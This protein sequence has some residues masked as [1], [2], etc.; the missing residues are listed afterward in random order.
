MKPRKCSQMSFQYRK[1]TS[2]SN[3][4]VYTRRGDALADSRWH[5]QTPF[6]FHITAELLLEKLEGAG[7]IAACEYLKGEARSPS[8]FQLI[9]ANGLHTATW[10]SSFVN[11]EPLYLSYVSNATDSDLRVD[12]MAQG[13]HATDSR[14]T[15]HNLHSPTEN[16]GAREHVPQCRARTL[17]CSPSSSAAAQ[18]TGLWEKKTSLHNHGF[19]R[20]TVTSLTES[21]VAGKTVS[22]ECGVAVYSSNL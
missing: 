8:Q 16:L 13:T 6:P 1:A 12:H 3:M 2:V 7:Q 17:W 15:S 14:F 11:V 22:V 20:P 9:M 21:V 4:R 10:A 5:V 19:F 18:G